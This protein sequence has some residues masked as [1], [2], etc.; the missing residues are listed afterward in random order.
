MPKNRKRS[1]SSDSDKPVKKPGRKRNEDKPTI[2]FEQY[3]T[4]NKNNQI[5][6]GNEQA[7]IDMM[8]KKKSQK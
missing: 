3:A 7:I 2:P 1:P 5:V 4:Q 6:K 8:Y